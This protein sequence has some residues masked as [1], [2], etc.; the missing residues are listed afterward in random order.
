MSKKLMMFVATFAA[1]P[2][3]EASAEGGSMRGVFGAW[4]ETETVGGYTWSYCVNGDA[5]ENMV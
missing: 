5:A 3:R 2:P 1:Y 4:A